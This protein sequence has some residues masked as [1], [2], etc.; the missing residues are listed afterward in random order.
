MSSKSKTGSSRVFESTT[1][2]G[3]RINLVSLNPALPLLDFHKVTR[4]EFY[5][6]VFDQLKLVF[7]RR[8]EDFSKKTKEDRNEVREL[9]SLFIIQIILGASQNSGQSFPAR[10]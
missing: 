9:I 3:L 10:W 4:N 1:D 6:S 8:I 7:E 5:Q 2:E